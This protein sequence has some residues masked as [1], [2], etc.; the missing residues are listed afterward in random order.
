MY[1]LNWGYIKRC[2]SFNDWDRDDFTLTPQVLDDVSRL[3]CPKTAMAYARNRF[4]GRGIDMDS[5]NGYAQKRPISKELLIREM[6]LD[7]KKPIAVIMPHAFSDANH[8]DPWMLYR[9]YYDWY[10]RVLELTAK[11]DHVHWLVRFHPSSHMYGEE[12]VGQKIAAKYPHIKTFGSDIQTSSVFDVADSVL[13]VRGT[14]GLEALYFGI[15]AIL[16]GAAWYDSLP[17]VVSCRTEAQLVKAMNN[18]RSRNKD[19]EATEANRCVRQQVANALYFRFGS[20]DFYSPAIGRER[21]PG[22]SEHCASS[23]DGTQLK[24]FCRAF[25]DPNNY[26]CDP[27][28]DGLIRMFKNRGDRLSILELAENETVRTS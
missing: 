14:A 4:A 22:L 6:N 12:G 13:T 23:H 21:N 24:N 28:V 7:P 26:W 15:P 5:E 27:Y 3:V 18:I 25:R 2:D 20:Y 8:V 19:F 16:S 10:V 9:T 17:G 1:S 11:V